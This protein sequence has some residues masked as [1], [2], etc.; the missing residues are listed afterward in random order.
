[1]SGL[2]SPEAKGCVVAALQGWYV[3]SGAA[4]QDLESTPLCRCHNGHMLTQEEMLQWCHEM[5]RFFQLPKGS[6]VIHSLKHA[7]ITALIEDGVSDEEVRM[8]AGFASV[9]TLRVYDH[10]GKQLKKRLS[11]ALLMDA[12]DSSESDND[13]DEVDYDDW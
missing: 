6:L 12:S 4:G 13:V 10:P 8:A 5:G 7:G 9:E 1:L 11:R 3:L 2:T